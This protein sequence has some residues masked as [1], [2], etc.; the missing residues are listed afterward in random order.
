MGND[1]AEVLSQA[2][3][4]RAAGRDVALC[5]VI[6]TWGS[7][8][9]PAGSQL[10]V[11]AQG[12]FVGSVS[13]GCVEAAV[14]HSALEVL[15]DGGAR[16]LAFGVA[17]EVAW[18][19]GLACGGRIR[20]L[21]ARL[22]EVAPLEA[23]LAH[24]DAGRAA[25]LAHGL[26]DG[27]LAVSTPWEDD[28]APA[29]LGDASRVTA[30]EDR[31]RVVS[32]PDGE[33]F[34]WACNPPTRLLVVGAVHVAQRLAELAKIAEIAVVVIDPRAAWGNPERFPGVT[35]DSRWPGAAIAARAPDARTAV[36]ALSHDPKLDD[37]ALVAALDSPAFFVGALGSTRTHA[38]RLERLRAQGIADED[39][40]RIRGP[41]GLPIGARGPAEIAVAVLAQVIEQLRRGPG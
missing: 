4:W 29:W 30:R 23:L 39:L 8:P 34:V 17:D 32:G 33:V 5:T 3:A 35:L 9:R 6:E 28:G 40:A 38:A 37:P 36:V 7:S 27:A 21:V 14:V 2:V 16:V 15:V 20:V 19:V 22:D 26:G 41:V 31:G 25:T 24:R 13:G 10:A 1:V 11:D 18:S 12:R